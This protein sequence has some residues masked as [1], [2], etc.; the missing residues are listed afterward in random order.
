MSETLSTDTAD[1]SPEEPSESVSE[2]PTLATN[3]TENAK[4]SS[5]K[6][7]QKAE[8]VQKILSC[9]KTHRLPIS[10]LISNL[11]QLDAERKQYFVDLALKELF[12]DSKFRARVLGRWADIGSKEQQTKWMTKCGSAQDMFKQKVCTQEF[13]EQPL[14]LEALEWALKE[15]MYK[16]Y[17]AYIW[18][19]IDKVD[20]EKQNKI[21]ETYLSAPTYRNC[22]E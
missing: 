8:T 10:S 17:E 11:P 16:D 20:E 21:I 14:A 6:S 7:K 12:H 4:E 9:L 3:E 2:T 22:F 19:L 18:K 15:Q 13:V 5:T 1:L